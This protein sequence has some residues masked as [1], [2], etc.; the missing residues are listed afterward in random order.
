MFL[1]Y[2]LIIHVSFSTE[3]QVAVWF[4]VWIQR[5]HDVSQIY[6][7]L[8]NNGTKQSLKNITDIKKDG[9][10]KQFFGG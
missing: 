2:M 8:T 6:Y 3:E 5:N 7:D 1:F 10:L 4:H 9:N